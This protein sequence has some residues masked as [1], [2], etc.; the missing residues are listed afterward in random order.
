MPVPEEADL[1]PFFGYYMSVK[2]VRHTTYPDVNVS[3]SA[4]FACHTFALLYAYAI[5]KLVTSTASDSFEVEAK[6]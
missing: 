1:V 2:F 6:V 3:S 5:T 4:H